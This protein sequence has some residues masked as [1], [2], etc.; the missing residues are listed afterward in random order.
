MKEDKPVTAGK[1]FG[2]TKIAEGISREGMV[3]KA[4]DIIDNCAIYM[5]F[6]AIINLENC[7]AVRQLIN[8]ILDI[9]ICGECAS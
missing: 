5:T 9:I 6:G 7:V 2:V 1:A 8:A 4:I 3:G